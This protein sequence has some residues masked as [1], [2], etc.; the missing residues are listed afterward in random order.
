[1]SYSYAFHRLKSIRTSD[2]GDGN[3]PLGEW[4]DTVVRRGYKGYFGQEITDFD[5]FEDPA[6]HDKR[7]MEA[8][9]PYLIS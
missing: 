2:A 3:H 8:Y 4:I 9:K 5:Y 7:N 6:S 1:M